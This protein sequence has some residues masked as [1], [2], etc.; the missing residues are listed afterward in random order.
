MAQLGYEVT[1]VDAAAGMLAATAA[2]AEKLGVTV[3]LAQ[4]HANSLPFEDG[5]FDAV[6]SR[7]LLWTLLEPEA[8]VREWARCVKAGGKI[9]S[10]ALRRD[11]RLVP[12]R[13]GG[14]TRAGRDHVARPSPPNRARWCGILSRSSCVIRVIIAAR[15]GCWGRFAAQSV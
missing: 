8:C 2:K 15:S 3:T 5:A 1:A 6:T 14:P 9:V 4:A 12:G 11:D 7:L 10:K 13:R